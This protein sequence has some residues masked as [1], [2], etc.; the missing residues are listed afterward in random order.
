M[1]ISKRLGLY[2]GE[3]GLDLVEIAHDGP[4]LS[5]KVSF[6]DLENNPMIG[7]KTL[8]EDLRLLDLL[9]KTIRNSAFST[10]DTY[11]SL[12]SK[13]IIIR[14]FIIPWMRPA[15]IEGVV[16]FEARKY[17]PFPLEDLV[18]TYFPSPINKGGNR[19]IGII[20]IS[21]RK[22]NLDKYVN[23]LLQAG[24]NVVCSEPASMSL[25]RA[26]VMRKAV[27]VDKVTA[28]L[29]IHHDSGEIL[30]TSQGFVKFTRDFKIASQGDP[31]LASSQEVIK[32]KF[33]NEVKIALEFFSRQHID[34]E[35]QKIIVLSSGAYKDLWSGLAEELSVPVTSS[36]LL[37]VMK[38]EDSSEF[39]L[40]N[41]Y[42]AA[43]SGSVPVVV[44]FNLSEGQGQSAK[45]GK[46]TKEVSSSKKMAFLVMSVVLGL[47]L[48][49]GTFLWTEKVLVSKKAIKSEQVTKLGKF[50][51][52]DLT[53]IVSD[54]DSVK[55][56]LGAVRSLRFRGETTP[57][58]VT[59]AKLLPPGVWM[60]NITLEFKDIPEKQKK[61]ASAD[62][63]S[64]KKGKKASYYKLTTKSNLSITGYCF[65]D[66]PNA[67]F[68]AVSTFVTNLQSSPEISSLFKEIKL[69]SARSLEMESRQVVD[70]LIVCE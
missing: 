7:V 48:I 14:W 47:S 56:R 11:L 13:D 68:Q 64:G 8:T 6:D 16:S 38:G 62:Q 33:F 35:V 37:S 57:F 42:G 55:T 50:A 1:P 66:D 25:I 20:F 30:I 22:T 65:L 24:L 21:I 9:Q 59:L 27:D 3:S 23:V 32:A 53:A 63:E 36:D 10:V 43:L 45:A 58:I 19:Q 52:M 34:E 67:E 51:A 70:F 28:V 69:K 18:Y 29:N 60:R 17:L 2:W 12:P 31:Q 61:A 26:L 44:D 54:M 5:A 46:G 39:G 40:I 49:V 15:E 4:K 41:A